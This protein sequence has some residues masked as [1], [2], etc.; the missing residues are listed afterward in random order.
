MAALFGELALTT[1]AVTNIFTQHLLEDEQRD[2]RYARLIADIAEESL[3][4]GPRGPGLVGRLREVL[5]LIMEAMRA[6]C[7]SL[8]LV[9]A[10]NPEALITVASAGLADEAV[11]HY[12]TAIDSKSFPSR[13]AA[14]GGEALE[15]SDMAAGFVPVSDALRKSGIRSLLGVRLPARHTLRGVLYIGLEEQRAFTG[16]ELR[17]LAA[18]GD[19]LTL[20]LDN[21]QLVAELRSKVSA[22]QMFVDVL[23]HDLRGPISSARMAA[24]LIGE[25]PTNFRTSLPR[26]IR[27]LDRASGMISDLL[28]AH[29]VEA[30]AKLSLSMSACDL[31]ELAHDV[32]DDLNQRFA[33]RVVVICPPQAL[34]SW[35]ATYL[36]RAMWNLVMNGLKYGAPDER[37]EI[38]VAPYSDRTEIAVHNFGHAISSDS[39][40]RLFNMFTRGEGAPH[41][42]SDGGWGLGLALVRGAAEAHGGS[43]DVISDEEH[44]TTFTI[45]LPHQPA[46]DYPTEASTS[47]AA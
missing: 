3:K 38:R 9:D 36:R 42:P 8:L 23:A 29:R 33:G 28:D 45:R 18:L 40:E 19:R 32:A 14:A 41:H 15:M 21:A 4:E 24:E 5:Q 6:Q 37:V 34:G 43:V 47:P 27:G 11:A 22:V 1:R 20:H 31:C 16:S 17:R 25:E 7:A 44:G 35:S 39:K 2:K 26:L 46:E 12:V 13:V 10:E 30:G